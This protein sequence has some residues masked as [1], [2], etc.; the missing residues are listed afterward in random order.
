[1]TEE[2]IQERVAR[3][4]DHLDRVFLNGD[5]DQKTYDLGVRDLEEW[6]DLQRAQHAHAKA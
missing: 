2:K 6:A 3:M 1:M 4:M 5:I